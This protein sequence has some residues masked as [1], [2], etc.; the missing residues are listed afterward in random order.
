MDRTFKQAV[1]ES[2]QKEQKRIPSYED[3]DFNPFLNDYDD[4]ED[5]DDDDDDDDEEDY[6]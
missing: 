3:D 6:E 5:D 1:K 4:D 2:H